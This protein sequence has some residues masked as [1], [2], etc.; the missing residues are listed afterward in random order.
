MQLVCGCCKSWTIG[1]S[2]VIAYRATQSWQRDRLN[3][4]LNEAGAMQ[5][6]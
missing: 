2:L 5:V 6:A 1:R 3:F 4:G